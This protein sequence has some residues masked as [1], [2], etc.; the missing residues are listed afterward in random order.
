MNLSNSTL[1]CELVSTILVIS[2]GFQQFEEGD[3]DSIEGPGKEIPL[4]YISNRVVKTFK[5]VVKT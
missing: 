2:E 1:A 5:V 4:E 3:L